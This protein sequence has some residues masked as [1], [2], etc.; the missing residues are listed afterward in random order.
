MGQ[1]TERFMFR[2]S[3]MLAHVSTRHP[4]DAGVGESD[5]IDEVYLLE[6]NSM[7][8]R[9]AADEIVGL[10]YREFRSGIGKNLPD[11]PVWDK[12]RIK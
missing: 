7:D 10:T 8:E 5:K 11:I 2:S 6:G 1:W 3:L 4:F 12:E 9:D